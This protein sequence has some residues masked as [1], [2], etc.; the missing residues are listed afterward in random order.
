MSKPGHLTIFN[1]LNTRRGKSITRLIR[2]I[3]KK[4]NYYPPMRHPSKTT[5]HPPNGE[6]KPRGSYFS[7]IT[8]LHKENTLMRILHLH[9]LSKVRLIN[10]RYFTPKLLDLFYLHTPSHLTQTTFVPSLKPLT[11]IEFNTK[12]TMTTMSPK[13][14]N[15]LLQDVNLL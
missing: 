15:I 13:L 9:Y 14:T 4:R 3:T 12:F 6:P 7:K 11:R 8:C 5:L 2:G 10:L 1:Y